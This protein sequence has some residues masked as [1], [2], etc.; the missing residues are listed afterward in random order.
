MSLVCEWV[1]VRTQYTILWWLI[2][3]F[4]SLPQL[5]KRVNTYVKQTESIFYVIDEFIDSSQV[6]GDGMSTKNRNQSACIQKIDV[7]VENVS[8]HFI[9]KKNIT[10]FGDFRKYLISSAENN[11]PTG[12]KSRKKLDQKSV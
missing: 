11:N 3:S 8:I 7:V 6:H 9:F 2:S 10:L 1:G 12:K 5:I 4:F